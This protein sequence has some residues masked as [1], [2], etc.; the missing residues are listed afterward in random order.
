M[1][2][3]RNAQRGNKKIVILLGSIILITIIGI[4][5]W[6][7]TRNKENSGRTQENMSE[8]AQINTSKETEK[9]NVETLPSIQKEPTIAMAKN[10]LDKFLASFYVVEDNGGYIVGEDFWQQAEIY[11]IVIDGYE[12]TRDEKYLATID[13]MY[14]GFVTKHGEDWSYNEFNDDI[15]WMTIACARAYAIT[16]DT[17]YLEQAEKHFN[18][19]FDR[20][21]SDDLGGGLFWKTENKTKNSCINC[22]AVIA[23]CLLGNITGEKE[24]MDKALM[25]YQWEK[26]NLFG[27]TGAVFDAYDL[28]TGVNQWSSTYNQGTFI[29]AATMLYQYS[30]N[31]VYLKDAVLAADY[32]V[33]TMFSG[34]AMNSEGDGNDLPG[35][36]GILARWMGKFIRECNQDQYIEWMQN[37][38]RAVWNN[39]NS[40]GIMWTL[41][42]TKSEDTFY[43]A[44][45][46]SAAVSM[47][48]NCPRELE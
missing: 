23:A 7:L 22:P 20:A 18:L 13:E 33:N 48:I 11:E 26:E 40:N 42:N 36:K 16:K 8:N 38:A 27:T 5:G 17:K 9:E 6:I 31:E 29:G 47:L 30:G 28:T 34:Q 21:W 19:V 24:Y 45:G 15:M 37:N 39:Q 2:K 12:Q 43:S 14:Q 44:W 41:F 1:N 32:T 4:G 10:S 25:I 46:C 35:F 3:H